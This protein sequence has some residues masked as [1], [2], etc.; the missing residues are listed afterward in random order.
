MARSSVI[1]CVNQ[2]N[3]IRAYTSFA[4]T[5]TSPRLPPSVMDFELSMVYNKFN[6]SLFNLQ[7]NKQSSDFEED[8]LTM[9][10]FIVLSNAIL[11]QQLVR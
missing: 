5:G 6:I 2:N 8:R 10:G 9:G 4:G 1:E 11:S 3:N 7:R